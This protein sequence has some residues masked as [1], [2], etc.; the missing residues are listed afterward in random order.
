VRT[1]D[2]GKTATC[3]VI[4][5]VP[6]NI[7][8]TSVTLNKKSTILAVNDATEKLSAT[9]L[10]DNATN[11]NVTWSSSETAVA[12]VEDGIIIGVKAGNAVI[13]ATSVAD[14]SKTA[15]CTVTVLAAK[16]PVTSVT[17]KLS[18]SILISGTETLAAVIVPAN[19]TNQSVTWTSSN[20][21]V[22]TVTESGEV[23]GLTAGSATITVRTE[24]AS[25]TATCT[26]TVSATAVEVTKVSLNKTT[27]SIVAGN[28]ETLSCAITPSY[29]TNQN[30]EW[31]SSNATIATVSGNGEVKGIAAGSAIITVKTED[32]N[33]TATCNVTVSAA[34]A[35]TSVTLEN[36]STPL[37]LTVGG[38]PGT[39]TATVLPATATN[40]NVTWS[41]SN[42]NI[43]TGSG[44]G[45]SCT[46]TAV[47]AGSAMITV[48][49]ADGNKTA[50]RTVTVT[51]AQT[52]TISVTINETNP[53]VGDR[54][55]TDVQKNFQGPIT[56]KWYRG[57]D[58]NPIYWENSYE[59]NTRFEDLGKTITV[60]VTCEGKI[61]K[62]PSVYVDDAAYTVNIYNWGGNYLYP[63]LSYGNNWS[64]IPDNFACQWFNNNVAINGATSNNY[65]LKEEDFGKPIKI[66]VT[67][68]TGKSFES[69][70]IVVMYYPVTGVSLNETTANISVGYSKELYAEISPDNATNRNVTWSSSDPSV[71]TV[72]E[73]GIVIAVSDGSTTITVKTEDSD[74][75]A[76]CAVTV[77]TYTGGNVN[78][79]ATTLT[80]TNAPV[81]KKD[82]YTDN[83]KEVDLYIQFDET[84]NGLSYI[85]DKTLS[86][87][88][89]GSNTVTL[90]DGKLSISLGT[91]KPTELMSL[92]ETNNG[93]TISDKT[94][95]IF[96]LSTISDKN[97]NNNIESGDE[98]GYIY[99][100]KDVT[101]S[102]TT[103]EQYYWDDIEYTN[104]YDWKLK[105]GWN[106]VIMT[107][108]KTG[109]S[110]VIKT[111][112]GNP[113][114]NEKWLYNNYYK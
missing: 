107:E 44:N 41:S 70:N 92:S 91:P 35:V 24:D 69:E 20:N 28:T 59:Y 103:V 56:Y 101:I 86:N 8:V 17:L 23:K 2:G 42:T 110:V 72:S 31:S 36:S 113:T 19:A 89:D 114:G 58:T 13:T 60:E 87:V 53:Q 55:T 84:V 12:M 37:S 104:V 66:K 108:T 96:M 111:E 64:S 82:W 9:V 22:A 10:P 99:S 97:H 100:D 54:L 52:Q 105:T 68:S 32:G 48:T 15:T 102:G 62:S 65:Y 106:A 49:T 94:A 34:I 1:D 29:A 78:I 112:T 98:V 6:A 61:A 79:S 30:L 40:K 25:K 109:N 95:S 85:D 50:T 26:V 21:A 39:L 73:N 27:T 81:A 5:T 67:S 88:F 80:I 18:T 46:V 3:T 75:T 76:T 43:A 90:I 63:Q 38:S 33:K 83:G 74:I 11:K 51:A 16:V 47:S 77:T 7:P 4:V 45:L 93:L 57:S 14:G 71:A